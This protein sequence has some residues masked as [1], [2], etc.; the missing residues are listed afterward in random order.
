[1][2]CVAADRNRVLLLQP[3]SLM[4]KPAFLH[5]QLHATPCLQHWLLLLQQMT[6]ML[7][8]RKELL[9]QLHMT[10]LRPHWG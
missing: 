2:P 9:L 4:K 3:T 6:M 7:M 1:V 5:L 8:L 10:R